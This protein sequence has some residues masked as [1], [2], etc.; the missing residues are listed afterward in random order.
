MINIPHH[1]RN[2]IESDAELAAVC[3][4]EQTMVREAFLSTADG[5][6]APPRLIQD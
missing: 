5:D 2:L 4:K 3:G 1:P 6:A